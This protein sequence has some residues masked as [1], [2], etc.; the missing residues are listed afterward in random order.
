M[1]GH[2]KG[3]RYVFVVAKRGSVYAALIGLLIGVYIF[4]V[5]VA[6]VF[7]G[8]S[9]ELSLMITALAITTPSS[10]E[11]CTWLMIPAFRPNR[12][13]IVPKVNPVLISSVVYMLPL[14][15]YFLA[16]K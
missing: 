5:A 10:T 4:A 2:P 3:L 7:L 12:L 9:P 6:E 14:G 15:R 13:E 11:Y 8:R 16:R 1:G